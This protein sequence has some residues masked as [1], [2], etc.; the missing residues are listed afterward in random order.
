VAI[1]ALHCAAG[2]ALFL[3]RLPFA[4]T[5][6]LVLLILASSV[7]TARAQRLKCGLSFTLPN[8]GGVWLHRE[9]GGSGA[10]ED[11]WAR[12][13]PGTVLFP[14][15]VWFAL[16][17]TEPGGRQ[18]RLRLM[19]IAAEVEEA[20]GDKGRR[21]QWRRLRTWLRYRAAAAGPDSLSR[22]DDA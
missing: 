2:A 5:A 9:S 3:M 21:G 8:D 1:L 20:P 13:L 6:L 10:G 17:W 18:R 12:V 4:L 22:A 14:A 7:L 15:V 11:A 16:A 19:L